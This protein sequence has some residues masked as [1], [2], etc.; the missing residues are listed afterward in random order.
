[1]RV[2]YSFSFIV[3]II[4]NVLFNLRMPKTE[5]PKKQALYILNNNKKNMW[6]GVWDLRYLYEEGI[7]KNEM[8]E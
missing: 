6:V 2:K 4:V 8:D 7:H 5:I 1:M 3:I